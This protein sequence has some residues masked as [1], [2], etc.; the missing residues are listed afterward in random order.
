MKEMMMKA[1]DEFQTE[2]QRQAW[3][4]GYDM[5]LEPRGPKAHAP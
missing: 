4:R 5:V 3:Q 2:H 1:K